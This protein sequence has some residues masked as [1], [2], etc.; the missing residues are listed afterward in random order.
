[1]YGCISSP[2]L[3][4]HQ[5]LCGMAVD[6]RVL[7]ITCQVALGMAYRTPHVSLHVQSAHNKKYVH[8]AGVPH[9]LGLAFPT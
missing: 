5:S 7:I 8:I 9:S 3:L 2:E 1:M 6:A 4:S